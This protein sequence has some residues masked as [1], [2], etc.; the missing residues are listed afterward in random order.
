MNVVIRNAEQLKQAKEDLELLRRARRKILE[1]GQ[2]YEMDGT[3]RMK[4]ADLSEITRQISA[5]EVAIDSYERTKGA[6][7]M[8]RRVIPID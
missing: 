4:R 7:G 6:G 5:Y 8:S 1:G 2:E 3:N